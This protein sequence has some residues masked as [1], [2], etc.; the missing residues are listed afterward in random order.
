[1]QVAGAGIT[2]PVEL[3]RPRGVF[4][5][6]SVE[7]DDVEVEVGVER[8]AEAVREGDRADAG[9]FGSAGGVLQEEGADGAEQDAQHGAV[10]GGIVRQERAQ[11]LRQREDPLAH[12]QGRQDVIVEVGGDLHPAAGVA[13]GADAAPLA[14][15]GDE[16]FGAA[17]AAASAGEAMGED[18]A[19]EIGAEVVLD[20]GGYGVT[21]RFGVGEEGLE[22]VLDDGVERGGRGLPAP[23]D[24][25]RARDGTDGATRT[26]R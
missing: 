13:G 24:G 4:R 17:V 18:A 2:R 12:G 8:G 23:I 22:V 9:V 16:A 3:H 11:A 15:E 6:E 25:T 1:V 5:E 7:D 20:P 10:E 19:G 14:G 26:P 21:D